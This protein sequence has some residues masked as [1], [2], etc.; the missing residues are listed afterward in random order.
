MSRLLSK[1]IGFLFFTAGI[2]GIGYISFESG[3]WYIR[4]YSWTDAIAYVDEIQS[5]V[6]NTALLL[7]IDESDGTLRQVRKPC[8]IYHILEDDRIIY[9]IGDS[10]KVVYPP[11]DPNDVH[12]NTNTVWGF[13]VSLAF[14]GLFTM[15]GFYQLSTKFQQ[16]F[17]AWNHDWRLWWIL[18]ICV[19]LSSFL[20]AVIVPE[21][22]EESLIQSE[23][24]IR[25][26]FIGFGLPFVL[27]GASR[28]YLIYTTGN[29]GVEIEKD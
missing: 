11:S 17:N 21:P 20:M 19:G 7:T 13:L 22:T 12:F 5:E 10:I 18:S 28:L 15:M 6:G 27:F 23:W 1:V 14:F 25:L 16:R 29:P 3:S 4:T 26:L 9:S 8:N 2:V 24:G